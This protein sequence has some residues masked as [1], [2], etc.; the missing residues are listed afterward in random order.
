MQ[1]HTDPGPAT[2]HETMGRTQ[3]H[4]RALYHLQIASADMAITWS[5]YVASATENATVLRWIISFIKISL[6]FFKVLNTCFYVP[7]EKKESL[8]GRKRFSG[9]FSICAETE[10]KKLTPV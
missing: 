6:L 2:H 10:F 4:S 9:P 3:E 8:A 7:E 5:I 1:M